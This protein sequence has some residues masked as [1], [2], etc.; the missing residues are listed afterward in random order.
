LSTRGANALRDG[1]TAATGLPVR[2]IKRKSSEEGVMR[3]VTWTPSERPEHLLAL[4]MLL[5]VAM[6]LVG[7][8]AAGVSR[9]SGLTVITVGVLLWFLQTLAVL[10]YARRSHEKSRTAMLYWLTT[11]ITFAAS[12]AVVFLL[13]S[14]LLHNR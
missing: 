11:A 8:I 9:M 12:Y 2:L 6:P 14:T 3:E 5:F 13:T 10:L 1:I 4:A 7:G